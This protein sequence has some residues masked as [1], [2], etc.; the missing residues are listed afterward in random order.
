M[1]CGLGRDLVDRYAELPCFVDEVLGDA[2]AGEGDDA[3]GQEVEEFVVAAEGSGP[4]VAVPIRLADDL[5]DAVLLGPACGDALDGGAAAVNE[6]HVGV[7]RGK[8]Q[9]GAWRQF[10][11]LI[12]YV[13]LHAEARR[14]NGIDDQ[15]PNRHSFVSETSAPARMF[16]GLGKVPLAPAEPLSIAGLVS[17][18]AGEFDRGTVGKHGDEREG[19]AHRLDCPAQR[20]Q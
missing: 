16:G 12:P 3:L 18:D 9:G 17:S 2:A 14:R 11:M 5:V 20:G 19:P 15:V 1:V 4:S 13:S 6:H 8:R 10:I 7:T